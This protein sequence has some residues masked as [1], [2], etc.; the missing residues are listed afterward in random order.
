MSSH[1]V[2]MFLLEKAVAYK[3]KKLGL[4]PKINNN[5]S[6]PSAPKVDGEQ[7]K[8][9]NE[10]IKEKQNAER[11]KYAERKQSAPVRRFIRSSIR[12]QL[13]QRAEACCEHVDKNSQKRCDSRF[14]LEEDH[15]HPIALGGSNELE[16]L[17]LLCRAHNSRRSFETFG[18]F[19]N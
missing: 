3:K 11:R 5:A 2:L 1:S 7:E 19:R 18:V 16:N 14:A 10:S 8:N 17:Q 13:W 9:A 4:H 15:I 12:K 6:L